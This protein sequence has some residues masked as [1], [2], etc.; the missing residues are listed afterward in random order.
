MK[1]SIPIVEHPKLIDCK[2]CREHTAR[3]TGSATS[4]LPEMNWYMT[5]RNYLCDNPLCQCFFTTKDKW[6]DWEC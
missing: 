4:Y 1:G 6:Y 5:T 3:L 2:V